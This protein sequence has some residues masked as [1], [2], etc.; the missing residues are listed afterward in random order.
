MATGYGIDL[1]KKVIDYL[2]RGGSKREASKVFSIGERTIYAWIKKQ[3]AGDLKAKKRES[4]PQKIDVAKLKQYVAT[5]PDHTLKEIGPA[6]GV[7]YQTVSTWLKRLH[8][9]RKKKAYFMPSEKKINEMNLK[10]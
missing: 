9:T 3:K 4:Y 6:L 10:E 1:R 8:I 2:E 5:H 7:A